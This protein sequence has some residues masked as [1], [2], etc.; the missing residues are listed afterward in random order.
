MRKEKIMTYGLYTLYDKIAMQCGNIFQAKNDGVALRLTEGVLANQPVPD[1]F[2][3]LRLGSW[4][5]E[6]TAITVEAVPQEVSI[7]TVL[8]KFEKEDKEMMR[9]ELESM[10]KGESK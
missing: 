7:A 10:K 2:K 1:D 5:D 3:L 8:E 4:N 9:Q 6:V